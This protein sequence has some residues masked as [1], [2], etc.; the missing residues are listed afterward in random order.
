MKYPINE[1]D[2]FPYRPEPF[3]FITTSDKEDL[4]YDAMY[5]S[6][7]DLKQNGFGEIVLFNK[8]KNGF[9]EDTYLSKD[10]LKWLKTQQKPAVI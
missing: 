7:Q 3:Y 5:K 8:P 2:I 10:F 4:S 1:K 6:L 9:N